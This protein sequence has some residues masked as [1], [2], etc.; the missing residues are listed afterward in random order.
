MNEHELNDDLRTKWTAL[1]RLVRACGSALVAFSGGVDSA[2][3]MA[4]AHRE[5]GRRALACI[6]VS[7][8]YPGRELQSAVALAEGQG[9]PYRLVPTQEF[10]DPRYVANA[11]DRCYFCK[12]ALHDRLRAIAAAEGWQA[13][14]DGN[15]ADDLGDY[16]P[17]MA[18]ARERGVRSPLLEASLTKAEVRELARWLG[19]PVWDK[20]AMACLA[21]RVPQ[22]IPVTP[23]L[24][25]QIEQAEDVLARLGF[26]QFRV[27]H[28]GDVARIELPVEDLAQAVA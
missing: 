6:G 24:L 8:S 9:W 22:G 12:S 16:R 20:P 23:A 18:A 3:V 4:V 27:R 21:S 1:R 28:H 5:L 25:R 13:V 26:R 19:L 2:L 7:P 17:G 10:R 14:L 11:G 15:N